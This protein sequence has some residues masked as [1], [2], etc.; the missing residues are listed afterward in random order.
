M[1]IQLE[2]WYCPGLHLE[3]VPR[4]WAKR[5]FVKKGGGY[6]ILEYYHTIFLKSDSFLTALFGKSSKLHLHF[7]KLE[8]IIMSL[9]GLKIAQLAKYR[10]TNMD[11]QV[12]LIIDL[13]PPPLNKTLSSDIHHIRNILNFCQH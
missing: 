9:F 3:I 2:L 5:M 13:Q 8:F 4:G 11:S 10:M 7:F 1:L 12:S 6:Y